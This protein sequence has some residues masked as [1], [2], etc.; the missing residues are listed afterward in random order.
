M[1]GVMPN[2]YRVRKGK[3][4]LS[5][6]LLV[7]GAFVLGILATRML[8]DTDATGAAGLVE[9]AL[10]EPR[11]LRSGTVAAP[12]V[13]SVNLAHARSAEVK[14][15]RTCYIEG[16]RSDWTTSLTRENRCRQLPS[17]EQI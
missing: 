17:S 5:L 7:V 13:P 6:A 14:A 3:S 15:R 12:G 1:E 9:L 8:S 10:A 2:P 16:H 4:P 11:A